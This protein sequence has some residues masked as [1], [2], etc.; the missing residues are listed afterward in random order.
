MG[1]PILDISMSN[2]PIAFI[3]T[4]ANRLEVV[5]IKLIQGGFFIVK[6]Y[7]VFR[8][9]ASKVI[10]YKK[11]A[12]YFF[13]SRNANPLD[14]KVLRELEYF[15]DKNSLH[16]IK[17]KDVSHAE[18]LRRLFTKGRKTPTGQENQKELDEAQ[19]DLEL[20]V[21]TTIL[22]DVNQTKDRITEEVEKVNQTLQ[23]ENTA[24]MK[25]GKPVNEIDPELYT[26]YVVEHLHN[27][28]LITSS[29]ATEI[30][31]RMIKGEITISELLTE[32]LKQKDF[33]VNE[34]I[35]INAQKYLDDFG[36]YDPSLV[37]SFIDRAD[38]LGKKIEKMGSPQVKNFGNLAIILPLIFG[39]M[40][41][42]II[43]DSEPRLRFLLR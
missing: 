10:P 9:D 40:I 43:L 19:N 37:D 8:I 33:L 12:V 7:G 23:D 4:P 21:S 6:P 26:S 20:E 17:R 27:K 36:T 29:D 24:L 18:K 14:V 39:F 25:E 30:K 15:A 2:K 13:D 38:G 35:T 3:I 34:P 42:A 32:L 11:Q 5:K 22:N 28:R 16:K 41:V 31:I 1:L